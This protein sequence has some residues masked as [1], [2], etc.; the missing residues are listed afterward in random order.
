MFSTIYPGHNQTEDEIINNEIIYAVNS[1]PYYL[2]T[3]FEV[4]DKSPTHL[5]VSHIW[6]CSRHLSSKLTVQEFRERLKK[7]NYELTDDGNSVIINMEEPDTSSG[8]D[9]DEILSPAEHVDPSQLEEF[10]DC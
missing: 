1:Q 5:S 9:Y 4:E 3:N 6:Q 7:L 10:W 2:I 8:S